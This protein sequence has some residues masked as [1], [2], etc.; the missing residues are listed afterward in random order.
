[1]DV[2]GLACDAS[3]QS[4]EDSGTQ[5][6]E[7]LIRTPADLKEEN[8]AFPRDAIKGAAQK[9]LVLKLWL[10]LAAR[11]G[12]ELGA[13]RRQMSLYEPNPKIAFQLAGGRASEN[14]AAESRSHLSGPMRGGPRSQMVRVAATEDSVEQMHRFGALAG[15]VDISKGSHLESYVKIASHLGCDDGAPLAICRA[16]RFACQLKRRY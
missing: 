14:V 6:G 8:W 10:S 4:L 16:D 12:R 9:P 1:M 7:R 15:K 5:L 3:G 2:R 11:R 13:R